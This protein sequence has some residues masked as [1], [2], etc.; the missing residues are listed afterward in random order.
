MCTSGVGTCLRPQVWAP[1][2]PALGVVGAKQQQAVRVRFYGGVDI[3]AASS[4]QHVIGARG[5]PAF[6]LHVKH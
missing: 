6:T 4:A 3:W 5:P 2:Q 1:N